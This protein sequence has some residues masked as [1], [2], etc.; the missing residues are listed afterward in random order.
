[1]ACIP[2]DEYWVVVTLLDAVGNR[3]RY[4]AIV[5]LAAD[6]T[7]TVTEYYENFNPVG[8]VWCTD[9]SEIYD[10]DTTIGWCFSD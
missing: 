8:S 6:C 1:L 5:N 4:Y 3:T 9:W 10:T 2:A 7:F